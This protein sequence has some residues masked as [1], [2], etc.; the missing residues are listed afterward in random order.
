MLPHL[1]QR[2]RAKKV[3][4]FTLNDVPMFESPES[5]SE[6]EHRPVA[7]Q[8]T[9]P[10]PPQQQIPLTNVV[11]VPL[12]PPWMV[13]HAQRCAA[14]NWTH[15]ILGGTAHVPTPPPLPSV[16]AHLAC[17]NH[18]QWLP[19][20]LPSSPPAERKPLALQVTSNQE[21]EEEWGRC[22]RSHANS[23]I[24]IG[25]CSTA[26]ARF[27][28]FLDH[29]LNSSVDLIGNWV[30]EGMDCDDESISVSSSPWMTS[31]C[32]QWFTSFAHCTSPEADC[33]NLSAFTD[34]VIRDNAIRA[35][36][37]LIKTAPT[38]QESVENTDSA[39]SP[40]RGVMPTPPPATSM[41][42]I[43]EKNTYDTPAVT[44]TSCHNGTPSGASASFTVKHMTP[45]SQQ[46][47]DLDRP[48]RNVMVAESSPTVLS[49]VHGESGGGVNAQQD[50][51]GDMAQQLEY[52]FSIP[53][54]GHVCDP[55]SLRPARLP[56]SPMKVVEKR[57]MRPRTSAIPL[58][59]ASAKAAHQ[60]VVLPDI[61]APKWEPNPDNVNNNDRSVV[62]PSQGIVTTTSSQS[63]PFI[64]E[65]S[66]SYL[67]F[68]SFDD[69]E[70][71][72]FSC[73][74]RLSM[75]AGVGANT[76]TLA[77]PP[78]PD[79]FHLPLL[80]ASPSTSDAV[81]PSK[82][83]W[84]SRCLPPVV[85]AQQPCRPPGRKTVPLSAVEEVARR[86]TKP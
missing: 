42:A 30:A 16:G 44:A 49:T 13:L 8:P 79:P 20:I 10:C 17:A 83:A 71:D 66:D 75:Q 43:T 3:P 1:G 32:G 86:P 50:A 76:P 41:V 56:Q 38:D 61:T 85:P 25:P 81:T 40:L 57:P 26:G 6:D 65:A 80:P 60:K 14:T 29:L 73:I 19:S 55:K 11:P 82:G 28:S 22:A 68:L 12:R 24:A 35:Q 70:Y 78:M 74:N 53:S 5:S 72:I 45:A 7:P 46:N 34:S 54:W 48:K 2:H 77:A 31:T 64:N 67:G 15:L 51:A 4:A 84:S 18:Q 62:L 58:T 23:S 63:P 37:P 27:F 21:E 69:G 52:Y 39:L 33:P 9:P 59:P 36:E 47:T